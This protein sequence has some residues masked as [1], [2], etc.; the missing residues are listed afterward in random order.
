VRLGD[1]QPGYDQA[2]YPDRRRVGR[3]SVFLHPLYMQVYRYTVRAYLWERFLALEGEGIVAW[4]LS[5]K[6][7]P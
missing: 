3:T 1:L 4:H 7:C 5:L 2:A 6:S